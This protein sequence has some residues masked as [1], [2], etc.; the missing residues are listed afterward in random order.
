M[1]LSRA[2]W[3]AIETK[4]QTDV[5]AED[6]KHQSEKAADKVGDAAG[7]LKDK[8]GPPPAREHLLLHS[9]PFSSA[10]ACVPSH[11]QSADS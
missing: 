10:S 7:D 11:L 9:L 8:V 5:Q 1:H 3:Q 2:C 4:R 6:V